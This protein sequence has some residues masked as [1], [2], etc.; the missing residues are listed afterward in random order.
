[1]D[2]RTHFF[3][4]GVTDRIGEA[5]L[6]KINKSI[7]E[8][9]AYVRQ[10]FPNPQLLSEVDRVG[11]DWN[12]DAV[13]KIL[14]G[15]LKMVGPDDVV[16]V[17]WAG[18]GESGEGSHRLLLTRDFIMTRELAGWLLECPARHVVC[19]LDCCWSGDGMG[20]LIDEA[21]EIRKQQAQA[22]FDDQTTTVIVS[23]RAEPAQEGAFVAAM[24][25]VL[26]NGPGPNVRQSHRW[27]LE[28]AKVAPFELV[29][30]IRVHF[31]DRKVQQ[32]AFHGNLR[33]SDIGRF[34]PSIWHARLRPTE[35][36][37]VDALS[38]ARNKAEDAFKSLG[39]RSP[40]FWTQQELD[41]H[42]TVIDSSPTLLDEERAFLSSILDSLILAR[43]AE[44]LASSLVDR[45]AFTDDALRSARRAA[46]RQFDDPPISRQFDLFY[47]AA[48]PRG[49]EYPIAPVEALVRFIARLAYEC[50]ADP[51][52]K[53][54]FDWAAVR[55][56]ESND[57][58]RILDEVKTA[59]PVRRLVIDFRNPRLV[60]GDFPRSASAQMF[61]DNVVQGSRTE[62]EVSPAN[63]VGALG[64]IAALVRCMMR[65]KFQLVDVIVPDELVLLDPG[66]VPVELPRRA[67][68]LGSTCP[69]SLRLGG[70][71]HP[72]TDWQKYIE[73]Y[74][75]MTRGACPMRW[76]PHGNPCD[77]LYDELRENPR[78]VVFETAPAPAGN[79]P[80][81]ALLDAVYASPI[82]VW[83][84]SQFD[85]QCTL[86]A[87]IEEHWPTL[88]HFVARARWE[89]TC[90]LPN[91]QDLGRLRM[92]WEDDQW[93]KLA[94]IM[95]NYG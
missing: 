13:L 76:V 79:A 20:D 15:G 41:A 24:M 37:V 82:V 55:G 32:Q 95:E 26:T 45:T 63:V 44:A 53:R 81:A 89:G 49:Q 25:E 94:S 40:E 11:G 10:Y 62:V 12:R 83:P 7:E 6:T 8:L 33:P 16:I 18:H 38:R 21:A 93:L 64:A 48:T 87:L 80:P 71:F 88:N 75:S 1:V 69:V 90:V 42:R 66:V 84:A 22:A 78:V 19:I 50:N 65:E 77:E 73:A 4:I 47:D 2:G 58:N 68:D 3:P 52:D 46:T 59:A 67:V 91:K 61:E 36:V 72:G 51:H 17:Y 57:V 35:D 43:S 60:D 14:D 29:E 31:R 28:V 54:M 39:V 70:R 92:V 5:P 85:E 56:L 23:A 74:R 9:S 34:F 27:N 86:K 30:A